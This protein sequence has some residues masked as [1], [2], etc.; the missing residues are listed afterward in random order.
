M[1]YIYEEICYIVDARNE[2]ARKRNSLRFKLMYAI[3]ARKPNQIVKELEKKFND[4]NAKRHELNERSSRLRSLLKESN[5]KL[6]SDKSAGYKG[7]RFNWGAAEEKTVERE[8]I[9]RLAA[10]HI[11]RSAVESSLANPILPT[12]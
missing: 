1:D 7:I 11:F 3:D 8:Q 12:L 10:N 4:H 6:I 5:G 9:K 2:W